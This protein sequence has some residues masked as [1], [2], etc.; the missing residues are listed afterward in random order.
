MRMN[1]SLHLSPEWMKNLARDCSINIMPT[2]IVSSN[3]KKRSCQLHQYHYR[4]KSKVTMIPCLLH[5]YPSPDYLPPRKQHPTMV[6]VAAKIKM[7]QISMKC[8]QRPP[9]PRRPHPPLPRYAILL[10][11][12]LRKDNK[13]IIVLFFC[14]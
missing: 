5:L 3:A 9:P 10:Y 13:V 2:N 6:V 14:C 11:P 7:R 8:L 1:I 12:L 4:K